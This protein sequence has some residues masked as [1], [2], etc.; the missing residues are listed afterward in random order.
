MRGAGEGLRAADE[1]I[2][3]A[4][5]AVDERDVGGDA[6]LADEL[7]GVEAVG[8]GEDANVEAVFD[9]GGDCF[10]R[11]IEAGA[12]GVEVED[13]GFGEAAEQADLVLGEG[14]AGGGDDALQAAHEDGD[15]VHLAF[16]QKRAAVGFDRCFGFIE[17]EE[18]L[19]FGVEGGFGGVKIFGDGF[20]VG[21]DGFEGAAREGYG[22]AGFVDDGKGNAAAEAGVERG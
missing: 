5:S 2:G 20:A 21:G 7:V 12:V 4:G 10:F 18:D 13:N 8:K 15:A 1:E 17:V 19:T 16:D 14:G 6:L 22:F 9:Q 11:G 3:V